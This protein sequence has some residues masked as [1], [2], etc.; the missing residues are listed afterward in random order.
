MIENPLAK[1][2]QIIPTHTINQ[3]QVQVLEENSWFKR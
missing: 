1:K 2:I 3:V